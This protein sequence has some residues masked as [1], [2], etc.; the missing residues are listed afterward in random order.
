MNFT[1]LVIATIV[2]VITWTTFAAINTLNNASKSE[3]CCST[4]DCGEHQ[5][6]VLVWWAHLS[7]G[8]LATMYVLLVAIS[9][10]YS[11][12]YGR[13]LGLLTNMM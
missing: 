6:D 3:G 2:A 9:E 10:G 11:I 13:K 4:G 7:I 8:I 12:V 1:N 5:M